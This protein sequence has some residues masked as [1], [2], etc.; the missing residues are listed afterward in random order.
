MTQILTKA[1]TLNR[2]QPATESEVYR[3]TPFEFVV[4]AEPRHVVISCAQ[5]IVFTGLAV[6]AA[7]TVHQEPRLPAWMTAAK[8]G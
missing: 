2:V 3:N 5:P 8:A 7:S 6:T 4:T 1:V